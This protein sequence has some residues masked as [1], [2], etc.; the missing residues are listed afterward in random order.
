MD[1]GEPRRHPREVLEEV[2]AHYGIDVE[3]IQS[4]SRRQYLSEPRAMFA[5]EMHR[6]GMSYEEIGSWL[7]GRG[8]S[9][10]IYLV[11]KYS[12]PRDKDGTM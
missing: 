9:P 12:R 5:L 7:G 2:C 4:A 11:N 8:H 6:Q 10:I 1:L 3:D